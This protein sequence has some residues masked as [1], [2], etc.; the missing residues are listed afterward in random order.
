MKDVSSKIWR[1]MIRCP[2]CPAYVFYHEDYDAHF[3]RTC[4]GW[5]EHKCPDKECEFCKDRPEKLEDI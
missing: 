2:N 3:C 1:T 4:N 5:G